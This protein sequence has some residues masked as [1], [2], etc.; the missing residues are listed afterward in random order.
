[1]RTI[2]GIII[3]SVLTVLFNI[4]LLYC[5]IQGQKTAKKT[6]RALSESHINP[7]AVTASEEYLEQSEKQRHME[8][9]NNKSVTTEIEKQLSPVPE[10]P[11]I[12]SAVGEMTI[13]ES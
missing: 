3:F 10:D 6:K 4:F 11:T 9:N 7:A 12:P 5:Y 1:M 8:S 13:S 2:W